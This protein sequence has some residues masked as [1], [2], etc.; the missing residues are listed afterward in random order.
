MTH[1]VQFLI[2]KVNEFKARTKEANTELKAAIEETEVYKNVFSAA[3]E[4]KRYN[5]TEKSAKAHALKV[6]LKH[7]SPP[8]EDAAD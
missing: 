7:Y 2:Q 6:A 5:V 3:L 4:D 1:S 8:D